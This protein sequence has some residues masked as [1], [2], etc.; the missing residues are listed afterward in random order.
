MSTTGKHAASLY[1]GP[2]KDPAAAGFLRSG[3]DFL[4][5][6]TRARERSDSY[7]EM[8]VDGGTMAQVFV[9]PPVLLLMELGKKNRIDRERRAYVIRNAR[10]D[11]EWA[12]VDRR[13]MNIAG[14]CW[15]RLSGSQRCC[16]RQGKT[17]A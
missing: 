1:F 15:R 12:Q 17:R 2:F 3:S 8:H 10:L 5:T 4:E 11:P 7:Q 14:R 16:G 9:Y 13:T 6:P